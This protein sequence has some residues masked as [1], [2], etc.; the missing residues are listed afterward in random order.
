MYAEQYFVRGVNASLKRVPP[1][2]PSVT[3]HLNLSNS[4]I[5]SLTE[6]DFE[7]CYNLTS[8]DLSKNV[9]TTIEPGAFSDLI[10]L[11]TLDLSHNYLLYNRSSYPHDLFS[12]LHQLDTLRVHGQHHLHIKDYDFTYFEDIV[13]EFPIQLRSL[14]LDLPWK[15]CIESFASKF[16]RFLE[17]SEL[18]L[19]RHR[20]CQSAIA[21]ETFEVLANIPIKN[22]KI[23]FKCLRKVEPMSFSWFKHLK[24]LD[25]SY[26]RG[27][28]ISDFYPALIGLKN[29]KIEF[30]R[31][32]SL[33][34]GC[35]L[36][37]Y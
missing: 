23:Q 17:L 5:Q 2:I 30:L 8:L 34:K 33:R 15:P 21:N 31:L 35:S 10:L 24:S 9:L 14:Y 18:G 27:I 16:G 6:K 7:G 20:W 22:L 13:K 11:R 25:L 3:L 36:P 19:F 4:R 32:S 26:M 28:S 29:T 1:V 12:Q 37:D